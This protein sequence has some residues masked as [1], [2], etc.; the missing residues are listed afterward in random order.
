MMALLV[1]R[2]PEEPS[3]CGKDDV[4]RA[5]GRRD[6][7]PPERLAWLT[8]LDPEPSEPERYRAGDC[9]RVRTVEALL[10]A[11]FTAAQVEQA[12]TAGV[13]NLD[14]LD[15]YYLEPPPPSTSSFAERPGALG[16]RAASC[17]TSTRS[18]VFPPP[19]RRWATTSRRGAAVLCAGDCR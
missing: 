13:P 14:D 16:P 7:V 17:P 5:A 11:G 3:G 19:C 6:T 2:F 12:V 8:R 10:Q 18:W 15:C 4:G 1:L 9:F